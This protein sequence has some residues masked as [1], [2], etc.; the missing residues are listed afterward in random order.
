MADNDN[1]KRQKRLN[2][3]KSLSLL[4]NII[5]RNSEFDSN[6]NDIDSEL[7]SISISSKEDD[8]QNTVNDMTKDLDD[9]LLS[10]QTKAQNKSTKVSNIAKEMVK[11]SNI[12][13][14]QQLDINEIV[15]TSSNI[16]IKVL[17]ILSTFKHTYTYVC[18]FMNNNHILRW[19]N[20][21]NCKDLSSL[22]KKLEKLQKT[23]QTS[24]YILKPK[25][26]TKSAENG[27]FGCLYT[28][29][30]QEYFTLIDIINGYTTE[31]DNENIPVRKNIKFKNINAMISASINI[32]KMF[33]DLKSQD[34]HIYS[35]YAEDLFININNGD[36]L[37]DITN[38]IYVSNELKRVNDE[39]VY[40]AP[41]I[42]KGNDVPNVYSDSYTLAVILFRIFFHDHPLEGKAVIDDTS[43]DFK[44]RMK[45]YSDKAVFLLNPNDKSNKA[46]RGV[47]FTVLSMWNKYPMYLKE[48]FIDTFCNNLFSPSER[49]TVE[50]WLNILLHLKCDVLPCICGRTDFSFLYEFT[51]ESF[52]RCQRCGSKYHSM[53]FRKNGYNIPVYNGNSIYSFF[54]KNKVSSFDE[55]MG[56]I[57]EN[58]IHTNLYGLK[59]LS[60]IEWI[61]TL[62]NG[63]LK[64]LKPLDVLPIFSGN[65]VDFYGSIAEFDFVEKK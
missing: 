65:T 40:L 7:D 13:I 32:A 43:L 16:P 63:E 39:C 18:K 31:Y 19:Y 44:S 47:N 26:L 12:D 6:D 10:S 1:H 55:V 24:N 4:D 45:Y 25:V 17:K 64:N 23:E 50:K 41:E 34:E 15:F 21:S 11:P 22:R 37:F 53:H 5:D 35:F 49:L 57:I 3:L 42:L 58:K 48:T 2:S 52:Y 20:K 54:F 8:V 9:I 27:C 29:I 61:C 28:D 14:N 62:S 51:N 46:V 60:N 56:V 59:N 33:L 30:T 36:I 38:S